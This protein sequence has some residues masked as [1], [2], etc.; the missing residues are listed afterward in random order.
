M[1]R[2]WPVRFTTHDALLAFVDSDLRPTR[3]TVIERLS[4]P[5]SVGTKLILNGFLILYGFIYNERVCRP[6]GHAR[7]SLR[8]AVTPPAA[9]TPAGTGLYRSGH[10]PNGRAIMWAGQAAGRP[11]RRRPGKASLSV[12]GQTSAVL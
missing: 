6:V 5:T 3:A 4:H 11:R 8:I 12:V 7:A 1:I 9:A 10:G 2:E